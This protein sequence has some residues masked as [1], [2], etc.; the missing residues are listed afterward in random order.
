MTKTS[1]FFNLKQKHNERAFRIFSLFQRSDILSL[2]Q[3]G[4]YLWVG[5]GRGGLVKLD[6]TTG[7]FIVYDKLNSGLS[8][9]YVYAIC[10]DSSSWKEKVGYEKRWMA[11]TFFSSFK[12]LFG[13]EVQAKKFER[14]VK[15]IEQLDDRL[16]ICFLNSWGLTR[17]R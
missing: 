3:E 1:N 5:T 13:E 11:E 17:G 12:K 9:N 6:K 4:N 2:A 8:D 15:E 7:E 10:G 16:G 14:M